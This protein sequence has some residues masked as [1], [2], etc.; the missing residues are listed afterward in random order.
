MGV[1][2]V[3]HLIKYTAGTLKNRYCRNLTEFSQ[4]H[5]V[6]IQ[7][8]FAL[9]HR[10]EPDNHELEQYAERL[11]LLGQVRRVQIYTV[12]RLAPESWV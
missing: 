7:T 5:P 10:Q 12:A 2:S 1:I 6:V 8:C 11:K 4:T 3:L 9:L